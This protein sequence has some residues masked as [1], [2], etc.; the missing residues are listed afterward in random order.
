MGERKGTKGL[1]LWCRRMT[2]GYPGVNVVN[3]TTSWRDGLAFCAMI[4]HFRPDLMLVVAGRT[5]SNAKGSISANP[6]QLSFF[7]SGGI[8]LLHCFETVLLSTPS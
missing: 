4:H 1:E 7:E 2:E 8:V 6:F 3:M 5:W